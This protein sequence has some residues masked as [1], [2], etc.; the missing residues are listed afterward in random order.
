MIDYKWRAP[1]RGPQDPMK[2]R[3]PIMKVMLTSLLSDLNGMV[4][5]QILIVFVW[6]ETLAH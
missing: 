1:N 3:D 5:F 2:K 6:A 4:D